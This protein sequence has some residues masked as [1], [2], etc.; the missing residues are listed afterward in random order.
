MQL[1]IS[2]DIPIDN[3][4]TIDNKLLLDCMLASKAIVPG[5]ID[6]LHFIVMG[7]VYKKLINPNILRTLEFPIITNMMGISAAYLISL[8]YH[9]LGF[10]MLSKANKNNGDEVFSYH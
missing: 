5:M 10:M 1:P 3:K 9:S 8:G 2:I 4:V 7:I 6:D